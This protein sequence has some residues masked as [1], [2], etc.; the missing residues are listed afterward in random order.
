MTEY[1]EAGDFSVDAEARTVRGLLLPWGEK[2][3]LSASQ[4][5]PIAFERGSVAVPSDVSIV[6]ANRFHDRHDPVGRATSIEDTEQGLVATFSIARTT[7]GDEFL[8]SYKDGSIRKLSAELAGIIRDGARGIKARLTGAGFVTEGAFASA[9]LFAIGPLQEAV[10]E[11]IEKAEAEVL[12]F[13]KDDGS[14]DVE[15]YRAE[16]LAAAQRLQALVAQETPEATE[17]EEETPNPTD[18]PEDPATE[19]ETTVAEAQVPNTAAAAE[20][21]VEET[22]ANGVFE[23]ITNARKGDRTSETMLAALAD[24]TPTGTGAIATNGVIQPTWLGEVWSGIEP[25]RRYVNLIKNGSIVAFEEKG[26][27]LSTG[28]ELV[29]PWAGNKAE[30]P[31][32]TATTSVVSGEPLMKWAF[33]ADIAQEFYLIEAG[34]PVVDAFVREIFRSYAR[35]SDK[36]ALQRI[37]AAAGTAIEADE[38]PAG[39]SSALGKLIQGVDLIDDSDVA[40]TFAVV[41][42]DVYTALRFT[43]KDQLPEFVTF[44]AG[45]QGGTADGVQIVRDKAGVLGAGQVLVGGRDFAHL[46]ELPGS[47]IQLDALDIAHGGVDKSVIGMAQYMTEYEDG[48]VLIGDAA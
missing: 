25:E 17:P 44:S 15:R 12:T 48:I 39:Y 8:E 36:Y 21:A 42:P 24:I 23:L 19:E 38:Y 2:S 13:T 5:E 6:T 26:F 3:R 22:P 11:A 27:R 46:N 35:V 37:V 30:L 1:L 14:F 9:A 7:E 33:A 43:P 34:K 32:G 47:P 16:V 31:T 18:E 40:P 10:D 29:K 41:A 28:S 20:V 45:R 4:T